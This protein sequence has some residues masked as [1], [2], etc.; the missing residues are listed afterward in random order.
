VPRK[1][2]KGKR[3]FTK[4]T[5]NAIIRYNNSDDYDERNRIYEKEIHAAFDKLVENIINRFK[6]PYIK[7]SYK[8]LKDEVIS[9]LVMNLGKYAPEKGKAFSYFSVVAKNY[10]I[11]YNNKT[12]DRD[13]KGIYLSETIDGQTS[14]E[15]LLVVDD[16]LDENAQD[17]E[18]FSRLIIEFWDNN[19]TRIFK[20][21]RDI[22]IANAI[23]E[24]FRKADRIENFNKKALYAFIREMTGYKTS[25]ITR[26]INKMS[27]Y[28]DRHRE[29]FINTGA[30]TDSSP[31][32]SY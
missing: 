11:L 8:D 18:E 27:T 9:F 16:H 23:I 31:F 5:E 12:Y 10:L 7:S 28:M 29:E 13:K 17:M 15:E 25:A 24:L 4:E 1:R 32:F 20:K 14:M 30:I 2:K 22:D 26:V 3:Y 19:L 6:F 21:D